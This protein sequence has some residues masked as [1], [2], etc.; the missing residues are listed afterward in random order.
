ME[1]GTGFDGVL[2]GVFRFGSGPFK[3]SVLI[4]VSGEFTRVDPPIE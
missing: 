3:L 1:A 2:S 4:D